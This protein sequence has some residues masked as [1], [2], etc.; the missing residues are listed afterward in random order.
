LLHYI[1]E[2]VV[3]T[4]CPR[5]DSILA[6]LTVHHRDLNDDDDD[7]D[8][9]DDVVKRRHGCMRELRERGLSRSSPG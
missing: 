9:K 6:F 3:K 4:Q 5:L 2:A 1:T 8:D 7:D